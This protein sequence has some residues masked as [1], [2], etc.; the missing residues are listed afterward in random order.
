MF[1]LIGA[2]LG[3][4]AG[5]VTGGSIHNLL[6]RRLRWPLVVVAAFAVKELEIRSPLGTS[7]LAPAAFVVSLVVLIGWTLWHH[8]RLPGV[9]LAAVGMTLNLAVAVANGGR[10]PVVQA[11]AHLGPPQLQAQGFWAE[12][13]VMGPATRLGWLGDWVLLP[14]PIGRLF[15]QAYSPGDMVSL[16]GLATVLFLTTRPARETRTPEAITSR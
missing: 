11:A 9:W 2:V 7:D 1:L 8:D 15:P 4:V 6:A 13:V 5:L 12:Y 10:M 16:V 3:M 14:D